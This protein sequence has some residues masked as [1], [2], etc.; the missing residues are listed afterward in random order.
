M[1]QLGGA[2]EGRVQNDGGGEPLPDLPCRADVQTDCA[3]TYQM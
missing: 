1:D 3:H 2:S